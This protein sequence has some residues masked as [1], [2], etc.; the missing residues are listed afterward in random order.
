MLE[1]TNQH[2]K[3]CW[4]RGNDLGYGNNVSSVRKDKGQS[5]AKPFLYSNMVINVC[6]PVPFEKMGAVQRPDVGGLLNI[7]VTMSLI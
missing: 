4:G 6:E 3:Q 1:A 2:W 5:A 7:Y